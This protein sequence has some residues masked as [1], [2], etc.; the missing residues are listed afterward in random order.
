MSAVR[1]TLFDMFKHQSLNDI[2]VG[3]YVDRE[4]YQQPAHYFHP[5][6]E[7]VYFIF[8]EQILETK[9]IKHRSQLELS[10]VSEISPEFEIEEPDM[11]C[12]SSLSIPLGMAYSIGQEHVIE[13]AGYEDV[14]SADNFY[15]VEFTTQFGHHII[16]DPNHIF[17]LF[18]STNPHY[19][20]QWQQEF[21]RNATNHSIVRWRAQQ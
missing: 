19:I 7:R 14:N 16:V 3:G 12:A 11:F 15:A 13:F 2:V 5:M 20:K 21:A 9:E 10:L 6:F 18:V 4:P 17:G 8:Q 1:E